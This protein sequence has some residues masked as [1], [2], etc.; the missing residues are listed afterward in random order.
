MRR[1]R[2]IMSYRRAETAQCPRGRTALVHFLLTPIVLWHPWTV[3]VHHEY[4]WGSKKKTKTFG[5]I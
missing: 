1:I 3:S 2:R 5:W 4:A